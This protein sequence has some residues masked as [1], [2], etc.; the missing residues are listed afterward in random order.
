MDAQRSTHMTLTAKQ[1]SA[2]NNLW[3]PRQIFKDNILIWPQR[4][5]IRRFTYT[6]GPRKI[7]LCLEFIQNKEFHALYIILIVM[8]QQLSSRTMRR[9]RGLASEAIQGI[10]SHARDCLY[11]RSPRD[12]EG[13]QLGVVQVYIVTVGTNW[14]VPGRVKWVRMSMNEYAKFLFSGYCQLTILIRSRC[15]KNQR[16]C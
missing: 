10:S 4:F 12:G 14:V 11:S 6:Y 1:A 7:P 8:S 3:K 16:C 13:S 2:P 9:F 15:V 5:K